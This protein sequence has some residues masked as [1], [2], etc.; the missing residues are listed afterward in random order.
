M[1]RFMRR[2]QWKPAFVEA[3]PVLMVLN[4]AY[5]PQGRTGVGAADRKS[6]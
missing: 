3:S 1:R 2:R 5:P 6:I 4:V